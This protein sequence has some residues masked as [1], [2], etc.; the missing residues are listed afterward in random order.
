[1]S[2]IGKKPIPVPDGVTVA[3]SDRTVRVEGPKGKLSWTHRRE[4]TVELN[5][6]DKCV[7]VSR[8]A[9]DRICR[10]LHGLTRSLIANMID[11]CLNGFSKGL[12]IYGVGYG[13]QL[14]GPKLTVTAGLSHPVAFDVPEGLTVEVTTPQARGDDEPA[15]L[16]V[17]GADKQAVGQFAARIR[18]VR[19][20]EP[21]NGKGV[22]Y[23][24]EQIRRKVGKAF[25]AGGAA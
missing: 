8:S 13:V 20:P 18:K 16:T 3:I 1:M 17:H 2:R 10:S 19:P 14:Q 11:G 24:G 15:R 6:D 4:M 23:A 21:Y 9:E 7:V 25:A 5:T 12:E 22:R